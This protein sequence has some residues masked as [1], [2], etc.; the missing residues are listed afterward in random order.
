MY[1][2]WGLKASDFKAAAKKIQ[3]D[4]DQRIVDDILSGK[5][6]SMKRPDGVF[7]SKAT[8]VVIPEASEPAPLT[9]EHVG[10]EAHIPWDEWCVLV[11]SLHNIGICLP[12]HEEEG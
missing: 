12:P 6:D 8:S 7:G 10:D 4:I 5:E 2:P 9:V 1:V 3:E 11:K